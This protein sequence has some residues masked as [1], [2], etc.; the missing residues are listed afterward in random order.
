MRFNRKNKISSGLWSGGIIIVD[1]LKG[2]KND[3]RVQALFEQS[4][5]KNLSIFII[6]QDYYPIPKRNIRVNVNIWHIFKPNNFRDVE[7]LFQDEGSIQMRFKALENLAF[8][9]WNEKDQPL[10]IDTT[11][12]E[13]AGRYRPGLSSLFV[14][15]TNPFWLSNKWV[16]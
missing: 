16:S 9:C 5:Q 15:T 2:K 14:A 4:G 7:N 11:K 10:T 6:S 1:D 8:T 13:Y 12:D 3:P